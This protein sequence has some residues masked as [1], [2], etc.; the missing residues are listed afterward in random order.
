MCVFC[1]CAGEFSKTNDSEKGNLKIKP[2][3][4]RDSVWFGKVSTVPDAL[5]HISDFTV[6]T[7]CFLCVINSSEVTKRRSLDRVRVS[8]LGGGFVP[9]VGMWD[10]KRCLA[11]GEIL[12][13]QARGGEMMV[14]SGRVLKVQERNR[15]RIGA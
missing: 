7:G 9:G 11:V 1:S 6:C 8:I 13:N 15:E 4:H 2:L 14:V 10:W 12:G 3:S 5:P